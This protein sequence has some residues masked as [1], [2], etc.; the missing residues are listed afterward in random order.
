[1][2]SVGGLGPLLGPMLAVLG[3]LGTY[4]GGLGSLLGPMLAVLGR[5]WELCWRSWAALGAHVGGLGRSWGLCWRSW[6]A[7]EASM[8][9]VLAALGPKSCPNSSGK[10]EMWPKPEREQGPKRPVAR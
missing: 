4:V 9:A 1:M 5:S 2:A 10:A 8:L 7:L 6:A 3:A